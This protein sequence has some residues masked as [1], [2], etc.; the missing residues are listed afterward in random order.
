MLMKYFLLLQLELSSICLSV[1]LLLFVVCT[2]HNGILRTY[3]TA[4]YYAHACQIYFIG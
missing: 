2:V 4:V 1:L 3:T